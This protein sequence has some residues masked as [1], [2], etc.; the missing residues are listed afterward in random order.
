[1]ANPMQINGMNMMCAY[2]VLYVKDAKDVD[3]GDYTCISM[4]HTQKSEAT[5]VFV[6]INRN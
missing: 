6:R 2:Q 5:S 3:Q 4:D 1:M